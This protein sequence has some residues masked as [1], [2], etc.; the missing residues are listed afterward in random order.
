MMRGVALATAIAAASSALPAAQTQRPRATVTP[1]AAEVTAAPGSTVALAL[2]VT[3][4]DGVHVQAT[5][6]QRVDLR[7][8]LG[9]RRRQ[10]DRSR[11]L[12]RKGTTR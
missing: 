2:R 5:G 7:L 1:V 6:N 12:G 9:A 10:P 8:Q 3:L 11:R 4:P